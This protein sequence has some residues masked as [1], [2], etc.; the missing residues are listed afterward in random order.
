MENKKPSGRL[1]IHLEPVKHP[2]ARTRH[3]TRGGMA[4][5]TGDMVQPAQIMQSG[6]GFR[7]RTCNDAMVE[8]KKANV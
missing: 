8:G 4:H 6:G 5:A 3:S 7:S 1:H 2:D